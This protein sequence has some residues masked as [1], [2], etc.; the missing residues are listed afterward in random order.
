MPT[1]YEHRQRAEKNLRFAQSFDLDTTEHLDWVVAAYFY[2]A[3]HW[4]DA[5]LHYREGL[6]GGTHAE[7]RELLRKKPYLA[8]IRDAY[9]TLYDRRADACYELLTMTKPKIEREIIP[10]YEQIAKHVNEQLPADLPH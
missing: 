1:A 6:H 5:L 3:M 2:A 8:Q 10:L 7:R 9:R 4:V